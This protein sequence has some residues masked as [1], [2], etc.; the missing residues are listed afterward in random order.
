MKMKTPQN[1]SAG[2]VVVVPLRR[3]RKHIR[4]DRARDDSALKK[5]GTHDAPRRETIAPPAIPTRGA[6]REGGLSS[7]MTA[8]LVALDPDS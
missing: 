2:G 4:S 7:F 3:W 8:A 1:P 6:R 5:D